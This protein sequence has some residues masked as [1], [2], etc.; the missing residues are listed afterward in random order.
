MLLS[1]TDICHCDRIHFAMRRYSGKL[2]C[3]RLLFCFVPVFCFVFF[4]TSKTFSKLK[5]HSF[6]TVRLDMTGGLSALLKKSSVLVTFSFVHFQDNTLVSALYK[7]TEY[8]ASFRAVSLRGKRKYSL[9]FF[10]FFYSVLISSF[11]WMC[12]C[13]TRVISFKP[14]LGGTGL[15]SPLIS[16][17]FSF[18]FY[19][20]KFSWKKP[21]FSTC[22][23]TKP[24]LVPGSE[25]SS[26]CRVK[27]ASCI[28]IHRTY[29]ILKS[30]RRGL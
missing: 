23:L 18:N 25:L 21:L 27:T 15:P 10:F 19:L 20:D 9:F 7:Q 12:L 22:K 6:A 17:P 16:F 3:Y 13:F 8:S 2:F 26:S 29:V 28:L 30:S 4:C 24:I 14:T 11:L 1:G 5:I